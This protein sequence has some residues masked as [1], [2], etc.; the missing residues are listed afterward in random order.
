MDIQTRIYAA[1]SKLARSTRHGHTEAAQEARIEL[2]EGIFE[3]FLDEHHD[4]LK[5]VGKAR[6]HEIIDNSF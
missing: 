5:D 3:K 6:L 2:T 4:N 1:R